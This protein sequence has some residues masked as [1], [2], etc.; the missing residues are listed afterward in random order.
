LAIFSENIDE[1][2]KTFYN[3]GPQAAMVFESPEG[4]AFVKKWNE[5]MNLY[6]SMYVYGR[7][8]P[9]S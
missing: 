3:F 6:Q 9:G 8:H 5:V 1:G 2:R 7:L 4:I